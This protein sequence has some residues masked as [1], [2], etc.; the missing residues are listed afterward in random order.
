MNSSSIK[1][2]V[3]TA[4]MAAFVFSVLYAIA[5]SVS[6]D[7]HILQLVFFRYFFGMIPPI[8]Y[9]MKSKHMESLKIE[10]NFIKYQVVRGTAGMIAAFLLFQ[11]FRMMPIADAVSLNFSSSFFVCILSG[12]MLAEKVDRQRWIAI[13]VGFC[14]VLMITNPTGD[15]FNYG[16]FFV[17]GSAMIDAY[18]LLKGRFF[19]RTM[20]LP[21]VVLYYN[22][23]AAFSS[24]LLLP[25]VWKQPSI[26]DF[27]VLVLIGLISGVGQLFI[28]YAFKSAQGSVIAPIG[29]TSMIWTLIFGYVLWGEIPSSTTILGG[30]VIIA[31]GLYIVRH[32]R[33][34]SQLMA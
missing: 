8:L 29:Y 18:V 21:A 1:K 13:L 17:L 27:F 31:A 24:L 11:A 20:S 25:F 3:F 5:K 10:R 32:A 34:K 23:F 9:S 15:I 26:G 30:C 6:S 4:L 14:G 12:P 7:Y 28:T 22:I 2:G 33:K 16:T 19:S